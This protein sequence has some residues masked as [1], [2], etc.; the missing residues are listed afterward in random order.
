MN[1]FGQ[2]PGMQELQRARLNCIRSPRKQR[3]LCFVCSLLVVTVYIPETPMP[4]QYSHH[5]EL[6]DNTKA[7]PL[8]GEANG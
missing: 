8:S 1:L 6:T 2:P 4:L 3:G 7:D 5:N